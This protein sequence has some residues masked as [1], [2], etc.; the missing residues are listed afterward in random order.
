MEISLQTQ[1]Q[2]IVCV[3]ISSAIWVS[4]SPFKLIHKQYKPQINT[5]FLSLTCPSHLSEEVQS[6][7]LGFPCTKASRKY[8]SWHDCCRIEALTILILLHFSKTFQSPS[9]SGNR[10]RGSYINPRKANSLKLNSQHL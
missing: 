10:K 6:L 8:P 7:I 3:F 2:I 9:G 1:P 5:N 4:L